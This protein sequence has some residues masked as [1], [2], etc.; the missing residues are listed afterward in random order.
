MHSDSICLKLHAFYITKFHASKVEIAIE[1]SVAQICQPLCPISGSFRVASVVHAL[2]AVES[3]L[4]KQLVF[5]LTSLS[6]AV[7]EQFFLTLYLTFK[8]CLMSAVIR[9]M[10]NFLIFQISRCLSFQVKKNS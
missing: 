10:S 8:A 4:T 1:V 2:T 7:E 6:L 3:N 5:H 9:L